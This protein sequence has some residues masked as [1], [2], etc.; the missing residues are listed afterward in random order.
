MAGEFKKLFGP[1]VSKP[2]PT[3]PSGGGAGLIPTNVH[4]GL[5]FWPFTPSQPAN[6]LPGKSGLKPAP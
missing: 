4:P 5:T 6:I 1:K 2:V 3:W